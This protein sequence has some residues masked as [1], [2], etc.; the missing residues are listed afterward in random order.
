MFKAHMPQTIIR[1]F[2]AVAML[3][4]IAACSGG[5]AEPTATAMPPATESADGNEGGPVA[6]LQ[7]PSIADTVERV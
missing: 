1:A 2:L 6:S 5:D 4:V 3:A 7:L